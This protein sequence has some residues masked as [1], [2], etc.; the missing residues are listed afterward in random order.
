MSLYQN[1][2]VSIV[3]LVIG[4]SIA[5]EGYYTRK[6]EKDSDQKRQRQKKKPL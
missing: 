5:Y 2:M 1:I 4:A 6:L 3:F